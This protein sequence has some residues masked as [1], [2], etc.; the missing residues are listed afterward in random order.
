MFSTS[1]V[2]SIYEDIKPYILKTLHLLN[3]LGFEDC[4]K[5]INEL[6]CKLELARKKCCAE[7]EEVLNGFYVL[8]R[9]ID[10]LSSYLD[11]W[12]RISKKEFSASWNSLQD[13]L[14]LLRQVK[15]FINWNTNQEV[16]F[17][18]NQLLE[19]ERLYPYNGFFSIGATVEWFECSICGKDIDSF[20]CPHRK[21]ELYQGQ[22]AYAIAHN[23]TELDHVAIVKRPK[24]K[25]CVVQ[26]DDNGEQFKL[27]RFLSELVSS[28][29]LHP[30]D[31]VELKFSKRHIKNP[32]FLK[33]GRNEPCYCGNG[34]KFKKC[35]ISKEF[36]DDDHVDIV[37]KPRGIEEVIA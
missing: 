2:K 34:K 25:R 19:L 33:K 1:E 8:N 35:C 7:R 13:A 6:R 30:L 27:M 37:A 32:E 12:A 3:R 4:R 21:G 31:F 29:K 22:M 9:F 18:E 20:D 11:I 16:G 36:I 23:I 5:E 26:Y 24:D 28:G 15:K 10:M 17:F 14:D